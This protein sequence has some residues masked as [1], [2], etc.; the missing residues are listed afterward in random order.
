MSH[1][2]QSKPSEAKVT[3][4]SNNSMVSSSNRSGVTSNESMIANS[5]DEDIN[6][7]IMAFYQAKE[8][9]LKRRAGR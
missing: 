6:E 4:Y 8:D 1:H 5:K 3:Q 2:M 7:D 9:L